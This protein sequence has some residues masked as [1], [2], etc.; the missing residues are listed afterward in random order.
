MTCGIVV[1][2][3]TAYPWH[4]RSTAN[5][6]NFSL[7][8]PAMHAM[9]V[10]ALAVLTANAADGSELVCSRRTAHKELASRQLLRL[11]NRSRYGGPYFAELIWASTLDELAKACRFRVLHQVP[12][13]FSPCCSNLLQAY[14]MCVLFCQTDTSSFPVFLWLYMRK[15]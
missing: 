1:W 2:I 9:L 15:A 11:L 14:C 4:A 12:C 8:S 7:Y 5:V 6:H 13:T 3:L 10:T